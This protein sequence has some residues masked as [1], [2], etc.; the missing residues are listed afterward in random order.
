MIIFSHV[1]AVATMTATVDDEDDQVEKST[2]SIYDLKTLELKYEFQE[3]D[4]NKSQETDWQRRRFSIVRFLYDNMFIAALVANED[5]SH[6]AMYYYS[7]RN[8]IVNTCLHVDGHVIDVSVADIYIYFF[9]AV[10]L[11]LECYR[12]SSFFLFFRDVQI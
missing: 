6:C 11:N 8:S 9:L 12:F 3:P 2:V 1:L 4:D 5:G 7:W 10:G